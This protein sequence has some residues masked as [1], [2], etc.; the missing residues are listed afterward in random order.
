VSVK[1]C[2]RDKLRFI[3]LAIEMWQLKRTV[4]TERAVVS[5]QLAS[6]QNQIMRDRDL[7]QTAQGQAPIEPSPSVVEPF[8]YV[9]PVAVAEQQQSHFYVPKDEATFSIGAAQQILQPRKPE[10]DGPSSKDAAQQMLQP[11]K[12]EDEAA[13]RKLMQRKAKR[14]RKRDRKQAQLA[15]KEVQPSNAKEAEPVS[16]IKLKH[17]VFKRQKVLE[18]AA[19]PT[20]PI[21]SQ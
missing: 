17:G 4:A 19:A 12:L 3:N 10:D 11:R 16:F 15:K 14:S 21:Q 7:L 5:E 13:Q 9:E 18:A 2:S 6:L 8:S 20:Y 1:V